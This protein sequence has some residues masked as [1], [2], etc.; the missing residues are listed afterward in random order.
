MPVYEI[1]A[2]NGSVYQVEGEGTEQEAL[3]H[4]QATYKE[5]APAPQLGLRI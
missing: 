3:A 1:T 5:D 2:P 4:F